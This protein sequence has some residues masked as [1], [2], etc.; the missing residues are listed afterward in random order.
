MILAQ[1]LI[2]IGLF[3]HFGINPTCRNS[4]FRAAIK[5]ANEAVGAHCCWGAF[6]HGILS[7]RRDFYFGMLIQ[8]SAAETGG[9]LLP[10]VFALPTA[11]HVVAVAWILVY[12]LA[13]L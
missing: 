4:A 7:D 12:S 10:D 2:L 5:S 3:M 13:G 11:L 8:M 6:R 9:Y 1:A